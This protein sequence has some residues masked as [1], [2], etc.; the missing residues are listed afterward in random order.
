MTK[1]SSLLLL[2][3]A[4][5]SCATATRWEEGT[6]ATLRPDLSQDN[7]EIWE[8]SSVGNRVTDAETV[9]Q[10]AYIRAAVTSASEGRECFVIMDS[11]SD[12]D[13]Y[14]YTVNMPM[15]NTSTSYSNYNVYSDY[16]NVGSVSGRTT[17]SQ[18]DYMPINVREN[19]FS[20]NLYV[21]FTNSETC[22]NLKETKWRYNVFFNNDVNNFYKAE[23]QQEM[24]QQTEQ[25]IEEEKKDKDNSAYVFFA[26]GLTPSL[27]KPN[28]K[29]RKS[30]IKP[31]AGRALPKPSQL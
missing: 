10:N 25:Q 17:T 24:M 4:L 31:N 15:T 6:T 29:P 18:I 27:P 23:L 28:P 8:I 12:V 3:L 2:A 19:I 20:R 30:R 14:S 13:S 1:S 16:R 26:N 7:T 5:C 22:N 9:K 11:K 21:V